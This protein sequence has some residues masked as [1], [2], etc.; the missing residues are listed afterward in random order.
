[1]NSRV[2]WRVAP[3][4]QRPPTRRRINARH[5]GQAV[6]ELA[7]FATFIFLLLAAAV[8]LGLAY[9][10]YQTLITASAEASSFL[11][12]NPTYTCTP[13]PG[14]DPAVAADAIARDRFR[15][16][17]GGIL[18]GTTSTLD[19]N[20]NGIDDAS[21]TGVI[22]SMIRI[23]EAD[24]TQI[25]DVGTGTFAAGSSFD[26]AATDTECKNREKDPNSP[27]RP[28]VTSCYIVIR[29]EYIYRPFLLSP[30]LG[31]EMTIRAISVRRIVT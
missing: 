29:V 17:Q 25:D 11:D 8:D 1:M 3:T 18:R 27:S 14:C 4:L 10:S 5:P 16:E 22:Q 9:K 28:E 2:S 12:L 31:E 24:N 6:V 19:L 30:L 26:P 15:S 23:D 7:L 13:L 21:E 20:S